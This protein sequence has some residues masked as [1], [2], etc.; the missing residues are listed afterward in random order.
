MSQL[1]Q[2]WILGL[3]AASF[4]GAIALSVCPKG[5]VRAV[6]S[7]LAGL[8][9]LLA[10]IAPILEFDFEAYAQNLA[11]QEVQLDNRMEEIAREQ[12]RLQSLIISEQ[13]RTYIWDKAQSIGLSHM[14]IHVETR[15][16][17]IGEIY[18]YRVRFIG[19]FSEEQRMEMTDYVSRTFGI[20]G[21]R[22]QWETEEPFT[23]EGE[24]YPA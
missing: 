16:S 3:V 17:S 23:H 7:L 10:L 21:E 8:I 18:P 11:F 5:R 13:S 6:L 14:E 19:V 9:T 24:A 2:T 4:L 15:R 12:E 1:I 20:S 22:Q